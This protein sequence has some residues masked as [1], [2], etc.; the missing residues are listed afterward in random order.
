MKAEV[1]KRPGFAA[2]RVQLGAGETV[3]AQ[4]GAMMAQRNVRMGTGAAARG[5]LGGIRR[6]LA[7]ESFFLNRFTGETAGGEIYLTPSL[8]GD[9]QDH[10]LEPHTEIFLQSGAF[11]ACS[12]TVQVD[13]KFQGLRGMFSR[14]GLFFLRANAEE[15]PGQV[16]FHTYGALLE[17]EVNEGEPLIVDNGHLVAFTAGVDYTIDRVRGLKPLLVGGEGLVLRFEGQGKVWAQTR[18]LAGLA[19]A[20]VPHLPKSRSSPGPAGGQ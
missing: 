13:T 18:E 11:L 3:R 17:L 14:E 19:A 10:L 15:R 8:P 7:A 9:V 1:I 16:F 5:F 4:P 12:D 2:V 20:L 6:M